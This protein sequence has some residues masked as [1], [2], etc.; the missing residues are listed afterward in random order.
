MK[1]FIVICFFLLTLWK[2]GYSQNSKGASAGSIN[3]LKSAVSCVRENHGG[4]SQK[5]SVIHP[6]DT[7]Q[8]LY[9]QG[10][11][12][13]L[14]NA[15]TSLR[16]KLGEDLN[17]IKRIEA[18][19][20]KVLLFS[21]DGTALFN[22]ENHQF[23]ID[24]TNN[25]FGPAASQKSVS[26]TI[27]DKYRFATYCDVLDRKSHFGNEMILFTLAS[28]GC[29]SW[30]C[31]VDTLEQIAYNGLS[32]DYKLFDFNEADI[33]LGKDD[34]FSVIDIK[35]RQKS[36][37]VIL[38]I[39]NE[40]SSPYPSKGELWLVTNR[41]GIQLIN[42]KTK[43][44][45]L[46]QAVEL[47]QGQASGKPFFSNIVENNE[48]IY[49]ACRFIGDEGMGNMPEKNSFLFVYSKAKRSWNY[50]LLDELSG[51]SCIDL[52][53]NYLLLG[54]NQIEYSEGDPAILHGGLFIYNLVE[55]IVEPHSQVAPEELVQSIITKG[56]SIIVK[57]DGYM[58][59]F[60]YA[61]EF[62][63]L[64]KKRIKSD[65]SKFLRPTRPPQFHKFNAKRYAD[66]VINHRVE[67]L[68][69]TSVKIEDIRERH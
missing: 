15:I 42:L 55:D 38:P 23:K 69:K 47:A 13:L 41:I 20:D 40:Y 43:E 54:C 65:A 29:Y 10:K 36:D 53:G 5:E 27:P 61:S 62:P 33:I 17:S 63:L 45:S 52:I 56:N 11:P 4:I 9:R 46:W 6:A 58:C 57:T 64:E 32:Q 60:E 19:P 25:N 44:I 49:V 28:E 30:T 21:N 66:L 12:E 68:R 39:L 8:S 51:V 31:V 3:E 34:G 24:T 26:Q 35:T 18:F 67:L 1:T 7:V 22:I 48:N 2:N 16:C 59:K 37:Y 14:S 50:R